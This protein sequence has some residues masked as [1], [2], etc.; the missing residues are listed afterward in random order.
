MILECK[1]TGQREDAECDHGQNTKEKI[2]DRD[3]D[4]REARTGRKSERR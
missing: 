4:S 3:K 2:S 1:Q